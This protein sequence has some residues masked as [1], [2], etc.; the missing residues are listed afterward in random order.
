MFGVLFHIAVDIRYLVIN[1][2]LNALICLET[3]YLAKSKDES[4][5]IVTRKTI[6]SNVIE[7]LTI[8]FC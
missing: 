6:S 7:I 8:G 4:V 5:G 2:I 3:L 1:R